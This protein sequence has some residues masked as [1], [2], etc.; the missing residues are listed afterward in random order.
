[1]KQLVA[2]ALAATLQGLLM[3]GG[4]KPVLNIDQLKVLDTIQGSSFLAIRAAMATVK[5]LNLDIARYEIMVMLDESSV[6]VIFNDKMGQGGEKR[7]LGVRQESDMELSASE[8][9][10]LMSNKDHIKVLDTIQGT[11]YPAIHAAITVFQRYN[12]DFTHYKISVIRERHST[13]VTFI[14]KDGG[15][16]TRGNPGMRPGFEVELNARDLDVVRSNFIR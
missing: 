16:H 10:L 9:R 2:P 13:I 4:H 3:I 8:L 6:V 7:N 14:D 15:P 11:S 5:N 1:M 12:P